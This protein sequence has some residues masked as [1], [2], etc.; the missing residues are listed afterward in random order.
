MSQLKGNRSSRKGRVR[1]ALTVSAGVSI[2]M[3][4]SHAANANTYTWTT[5]SDGNWSAGTWTTIAPTSDATNQLA[6]GGSSSYKAT[7]D[8]AATPFFLGGITFSNTAG[9]VTLAGS[10]TANVL[11][12]AGA[13]APAIT[14]S[15]TGSATITASVTYANDM[16]ITNTGSGTLTLGG[17]TSSSTQ[18]YNGTVTITNSGTGNMA[19]GDGASYA[20][21]GTINLANTSSSGTMMVGDI[22]AGTGFAGT[23]NITAG[24]VSATNTGGNLFA[25]TMVLNVANGATFNFNSNTESMGGISGQG[26]IIL[27]A[28]GGTHL[29]SLTL[30]Q[31]GIRTFGGNFSGFGVITQSAVGMFTLTGDSTNNPASATTVT[32][33]VTLGTLVYAGT[34]VSQGGTTTGGFVSGTLT[35]SPFGIGSVSLSGGT[36]ASDANNRTLANA[37]SVTAS[38]TTNVDVPAGAQFTW[39]GALAGTGTL[40]KIGAGQLH[41]FSASTFTG[42]VS[43][44]GGSIVSDNTV[45]DNT[46]QLGTGTLTL[47]SGSLSLLGNSSVPSSQTFGAVNLQGGGELDLTANGGQTAQIVTGTVTRVGVSASNFGP[48]INFNPTNVNASINTPILNGSNGIVGAYA[49]YNGN[50]WAVTGA[51]GPNN[52]SGLASGSY[53]PL[54]AGTNHTD[55]PAVGILGATT[56]TYDVRFNTT[57]VTGV[58]VTLS[59]ANSLGGGG[60]LVTSAMGNVT[61]T[62]SGSGTLTAPQGVELIVQQYNPSGSLVISSKILDTPNTSVSQSGVTLSTGTTYTLSAATVASLYPGELVTSSVGPGV[63]PAGDVVMKINSSTSI[64][65]SAGTSAGQTGLATLTFSGGTPLTKSGPGL[66]QL[67]ATGSTF[68]GPLILNGGTVQVTTGGST[69]TLGTTPSIYFNGG[70]LLETASTGTGPVWFIGAG[71]GTLQLVGSISQIG[72]GITGTGTLTLG[73]TGASTGSV[74]I[75]SNSSPFNGPVVLN[76]GA[77]LKFTSNQ[78][79]SISGMTV[80]AG[81]QYQINDTGIGGYNFAAGTTLALN[82][83]GPTGSTTPGAMAITVQGSTS[84]VG[85]TSTFSNLIYLA[86]NSEIGAYSSASHPS[87]VSSLI[88]S[89]AISGPGGLT[90]NGNGIVILS[91]SNIYTG[92]TTVNN[93][94]ATTATA[95]NLILNTNGNTSVPGNL[96]IGNAGTGYA[97]VQTTQANQFGPA[98]VVSFNDAASKFGYLQLLGNNQIVA[99]ISDTDGN[100][101]IENTETQTSVGNSILTVNSSTNASFNGFLRDSNAGGSGTLALTKMGSGTF[102]LAGPNITYSGP[103]TV[104]GGTLI[105]SSSLS[106]GTAVTVANLGTLAGHGI[107]NGSVSVLQGGTIAVGIGARQSNA[108][109]GTFTI[110]T[111]GLTTTTLSTGS[112]YQWGL[113]SATNVTGGAGHDWDLLAISGLL[114]ANTGDVI[115]KPIALSSS[116]TALANTT[117]WDIAGGTTSTGAAIG[118]LYS[119][120]QLDPTALAIFAGD[121]GVPSSSFSVVNDGGDVAI[122][123]TAA[124]EPTSMMLLGLGV[125]G[126]ALRR[127]RNRKQQLR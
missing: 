104:N 10:P 24:T 81:G 27:G 115:I 12:F 42:S 98:S 1:A 82:G 47:G 69:G 2:A 48:T 77:A 122:Q 55:V 58:A 21:T 9:T 103:T 71:G 88:L 66:L 37:V 62:I 49:V 57:N 108:A 26:N 123:F 110:G 117:I 34:P 5:A 52:V 109:P 68:Q 31:A 36:L 90:T 41:L 91:G 107:V 73:S 125:S 6:F 80:N 124:P 113:L 25:D 93:S 18:T 19:L 13:T 7:D 74:S 116:P 54:W 59:G 102:T 15:G 43:V 17:T 11:S 60:I 120:F 35:S 67:T 4:Q 86:G 126:L 112:Y 70:T 79:T 14:S 56:G 97:V 44:N 20:G 46:N 118:T 76:N 64:T 87:A 28:D 61:S 32:A 95:G 84:T 111:D 63:L 92:S 38:K 45:S 30:V 100:A 119:Q 3:L 78:F 127:R 101:I 39:T 99:G 94:G 75:G 121:V 23:L 29:A 50:T 8:N 106:A 22:G 114:A 16:A 53:S 65:L 51:S 72:G 89:G 96:T 105:V 85:P 40:N 33:S 83:T